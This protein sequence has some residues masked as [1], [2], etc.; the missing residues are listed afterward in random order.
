MK[1]IKESTGEEMNRMDIIGQNGNDG[2]HYDEVYAI[3]YIEENFPETAK[4]FQQIQYEQWVIFCR[5]QMDY[6]PS[7]IAMGTSLSTPEDKRLSMIGL[8]VRINDKIQRLMNLVIKHNRKA[9]NE[10]VIDAFK[11]LSVYGIIA[12]IVD[13]GKW[14]K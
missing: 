5:K 10:P 2:E 12:Q 3:K 8:I 7:N 4:E 6:G 11:D 9:Q 1:L 14:G 13:N